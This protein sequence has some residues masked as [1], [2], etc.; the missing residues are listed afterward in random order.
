M[1]DVEGGKLPSPQAEQEQKLLDDKE[2]ARSLNPSVD[3]AKLEG[4]LTKSLLFAVIAVTVGSSF[5]FG[6]H[7][8]CVNAPGKLITEWF[9]VS[10]KHLYNETLTAEAADFQWSIAVGI[11]AVG[12]M[13]GGLLS[14]WLADK[15][16]RKGA[17]LFNNIFALL[18]AALMA[19][20]KYVDVYYLLTVGRLVIGFNCGLSSGLVPMYLT[21]VSPINLRG[22]LGSVH[23]LLVTISILVSQILGL[24]FLLGTAERWP[25]IFAFT[26]VPCIFQLITLPLC[27]ESP[28]HNLINKGN[29]EQA[30]NDLKKLRDSTDVHVELDLV[31]EEAAAA[32]NQSKVT[33]SQLFVGVLKWP[34]FI[35]IMMMFSQQFSGINVAM[36]Y[37][38]KVFRDAGLQG[39]G[40]IYATIA[41]G[42][43][44]VAQ[45][46]VSL[47]LVDHPKF[48]RR[49]LHL[50][51]LIGMLISS[52][53]IVA[54]L[55][56]AGTNA[57]GEPENQWASY[58]SII[59]VLLFVVAFATGPGSI[60][61]FFVSEIFPSSARG[62]AASVAT[63]A[64]WLANFLVGVSFLPL[65]N[66]LRQY[67]F[68]VFS[69]LLGIFIVFT[70]K[71]VPETKGK[72][73][74]E[75]NKQMKKG[76]Q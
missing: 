45:T 64:N 32:R 76:S 16:G 68:L 22:A 8:G 69:F 5:Q 73:L 52:L 66:I 23:Q 43:I 39:N 60:P 63:L 40:P 6:Y 38:T 46:V 25:Y 47:W 48:G 34:L 42:A 15:M 19:L 56:I 54:S 61:W 71:F 41:M 30:E 51:G 31:K 1:T 37:S 59:F 20:A 2:T 58:A 21:E 75:I 29:T 36:F 35:A 49:S 17:L 26:V 27:P 44:N 55:T 67:S 53:L 9:K 70:Y 11:F 50:A 65:N 72:T 18:A 74:D 24:P 14:G 28:K 12:G 7:I 62:A 13:V 57:R 3:P 33:I 10:H 4:K